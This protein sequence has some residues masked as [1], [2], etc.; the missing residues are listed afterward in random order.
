MIT[1]EDIV[2][3]TFAFPLNSHER[4][5]LRAVAST[6]VRTQQQDMDPLQFEI[7]FGIFAWVCLTTEIRE[8]EKELMV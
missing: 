8:R 5:Y 1:Y 2:T 7:R 6:M 3:S 4:A